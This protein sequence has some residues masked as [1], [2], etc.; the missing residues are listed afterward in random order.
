LPLPRT[1]PP[2]GSSTDHGASAANG[3]NAL[4]ES[5]HS[6][7]WVATCR[8]LTSSRSGLNAKTGSMVISAALIV[9][10]SRVRYGRESNNFCVSCIGLIT[11]SYSSSRKVLV[12]NT[13][14]ARSL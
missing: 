14:P 11:S 8:L 6:S 5:S 13:K 9:V 1:V 2:C 10:Y 3:A 4:L 7:V 12:L